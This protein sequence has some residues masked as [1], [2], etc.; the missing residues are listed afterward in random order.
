MFLIAYFASGSRRLYVAEKRQQTIDLT[1]VENRKY[2][3]PIPNLH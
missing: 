1:V 2:M 3:R